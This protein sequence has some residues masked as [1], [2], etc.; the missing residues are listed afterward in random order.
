MEQL[1]LFLNLNSKSCLIVG[2]GSVAERKARMLLRAGA[3]L[4]VVAPVMN[5]YFMSLDPRRVKLLHAAFKAEMCQGQHLVIAATG[6]DSVNQQ[7]ADAARKLAVWC[8]VVDQAE[9]STAFVPAII[10]RS[11][12]TI[13]VGT[14]GAS[15]TL[16]RRIK[17]QIEAMLPSRLGN[18]AA[19][20]GRWRLKV[21]RRLRDSEDRRHFWERVVSGPIAG[22]LLAGRDSEAE[23]E[24]LRLL[25]DPLSRRGQ[26]EAYLVGAG[27]GDVGLM[28]LRGHQLLS[29]ADIVLHDALIPEAI[30]D[31]ARRDA[32]RVSV[33]KRPGESHKQAEITR[34]LVGLVRKG[35]RVCRLKGGD[36]LIFGRGG[37]EAKA[38]E[39][40]GLPFEIVPGVSAAQGCAASVGIPLTYRGI[41]NSVT[42]ATGITI[43]GA[44]PDWASLAR[45]DQTLAL[46]MGV[47]SLEHVTAQLIIHGL[48]AS[49]PAALVENGTLPEERFFESTLAKIA[50]LASQQGINS[51]AILFVGENLSLRAE[52]SLHTLWNKENALIFH[53]VM[54]A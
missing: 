39:K 28:T 11:P 19:T 13:A 32:K 36:P 14:G 17:R 20:L 21:K 26:G 43:G 38:L 40:E 30:L 48:A 42:F 49:T 46:Y 25:D 27:P 2:A 50:D 23:Q 3:S 44:E 47:R 41:S 51:P 7:V 54:S 5:D 31:L 8:N 9:L 6:V 52:P 34:S 37:E 12:V 10:D 16:A 35:Y 29:Q 22:H 1:P 18:L 33:G 53:N 4:T 15:P 24:F 45:A